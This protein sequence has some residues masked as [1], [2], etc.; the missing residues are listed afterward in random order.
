MHKR[1]WSRSS[2]PPG[3]YLNAVAIL[4][5]RS[6]CFFPIVSS[7]KSIMQFVGNQL[8]SCRSNILLHVVNLNALWLGGPL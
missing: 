4:Q 6:V 2:S 3:K 7:I 8:L 1:T 5:Y